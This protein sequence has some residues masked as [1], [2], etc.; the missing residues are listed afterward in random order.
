MK[1][2]IGNFVGGEIVRDFL[3]VLIAYNILDTGS[4]R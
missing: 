1:E 3:A 2:V 4:W